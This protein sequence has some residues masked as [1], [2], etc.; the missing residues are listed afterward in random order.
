MTSAQPRV[1]RL[2]PANVGPALRYLSRSPYENVFLTYLA[3]DGTPAMQRDVHVVLQSSSNVVGVGFLGRQIVLAAEPEG[4]EALAQWPARS[5]ERAIVGPRDVV[6]AYWE[7][8][9][10]HHARPRLVREHQPVMAVDEATLLRGD[11]PVV[12]RR[13]NDGDRHDVAQNSAAM[14]ASELETQPRR[15]ADFDAAIRTMI[16]LGLWWVGESEGRL[17]FFCNVGAWSPQ[18]AQLQGIWTPPALRGRGLATAALA[19]ICRALLNVV[20]TLSLY[21]NDFNAPAI[22]LYRRLGFREVGELQTILF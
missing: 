1:E 4:S 18:T 17:C 14:I 9:R 6:R 13:A 3:M 22:A 2:S 12:V 20:P 10:T 15:D 19:A 21:V 8:A 7:R 11:V 5:G 16:R